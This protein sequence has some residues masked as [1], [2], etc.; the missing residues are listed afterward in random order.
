[1]LKF[2]IGGAVASIA[3]AAAAFGGLQYAQIRAAA[4]VEGRFNAIRATGATASHGAVTFDLWNRGLR[5]KDVAIKSAAAPASDIAIAEIAFDGLDIWAKDL[6][7]AHVDVNSFTVK[8][9]FS[10]DGSLP[11]EIKAPKIAMTGV[12][13]L[14][15][16]ADLAEAKTPAQQVAAQVAAV[17][18][19]SIE[20]PELSNVIATPALPLP[21][22]LPDANGKPVIATY[23]YSNVK[24]T[25]VRDGKFSAMVSDK[26][27]ITGNPGSPITLATVAGLSMTDFDMMPYFNLGLARR[28]ARNGYYQVQG[29]GTLG[30]Y[31]V[32]LADGSTMELKGMRAGPAGIDPTKASVARFS[33][34]FAA[35]SALGPR[36]TPDQA[37]KFAGVMGDIYEGLQ[38]TGMDV[39]G[40]RLRGPKTGPQFEA[41]VGAITMGLLEKGKLREFRVSDVSASGA[42]GGG[43]AP[44]FK[45][46]T[47]AITGLDISR[48]FRILGTLP[49]AGQPPSPDK[50]AELMTSIEGLEL[51]GIAMP[52][53]PTGQIV[54]L[55]TFNVGWGRFVNNIPS[56]ARWKLNGIFPLDAAD[57][58]A[59][60][61][62]K[63]GIPNLKIA[64]EASLNWIEAD[65]L[66]D[67]KLD[68][69]IGQLGALSSTFGLGNVPRTA[70]STQPDQLA[71]AAAGFEIG[72]L[73]L[74]MRDQGAV[75]AFNTMTNA[76]APSSVDPAAPKA[77]P[78]AALRQAL[79]DPAQPNSNIATLLDS[80]SQFLAAPGQTIALRLVPKAPINL[81]ELTAPDALQQ[82]GAIAALLEKFTVD[83]KVTP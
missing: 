16:P 22:S 69:S 81:A 56:T 40:F 31:T 39:N 3:L 60:A 11:F 58:S 62:R 27:T 71:A 15:T 43:G 76:N 9:S 25:N 21:P 2:W 48:I 78:L 28:T 42:P 45:L 1:M 10:T 44:P 30:T 12:R 6:V 14:S 19:A 20:A 66:L 65:R 29:A 5:I 77:D 73:S 7:A 52:A 35:M 61:L 23:V 33:E 59:Q 37:A 18:A 68:V 32:A 75:K 79:V 34:M 72:P 80:V 74:T 82:P 17:S 64:S 41:N 26:A 54:Q 49:P 8:A 63:L 13:V 83:A 46:G 4:E 55:D 50:M 47:F 24:I 51:A 53:P 36:A 38:L 67:T 70:F 57:P